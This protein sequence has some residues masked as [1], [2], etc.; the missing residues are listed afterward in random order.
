[1]GCDPGKSGAAVLIDD[2]GYLMDFADFMTVKVGKK[3]KLAIPLFA[4]YVHDHWLYDMPRSH[5]PV[6]YIEQVGAMPKQ[7]VTSSFDFGFSTGVAHGVFA[8]HG[9]RIE[10]IRPQAWKKA[11]GL[12]KTEKDAARFWAMN[13]WPDRASWFKRAKDSG[14]AD[15][16]A[17][18]W[19][20][21]QIENGR[22]NLA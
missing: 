12:L 16:A 13:K 2:D 9:C 10:T 5:I 19:V 20:G 17:M 8:A 15:A 18:A 4:N 11:T 14:R 21:L 22:H 6:V 1:M 3:N 7:G